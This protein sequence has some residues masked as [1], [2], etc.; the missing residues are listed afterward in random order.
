MLGGLVTV[1]AGRLIETAKLRAAAFALYAGAAAS[2]LFALVFALVALRHWIAVTYA[3]QYPELWIALLF[4]VVA[5]ICGGIGVFLRY[6]KPRTNALAD[7]ALLAGP[8]LFG[9]AARN[10]RKLSPRAVGVG[11]VL[12]GGLLLG[13]SLMK[14]FS[15]PADD[16]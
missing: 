6:R 10:A 9:L 1:L 5:L 16:A 7:V 12:L 8:T 13:R 4:V 14:G 11:V 3:S 15:A 2:L